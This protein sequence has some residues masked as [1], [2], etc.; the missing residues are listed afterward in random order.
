[1]EPNYF[2]A[3]KDT[4]AFI[5]KRP[6]VFGFAC[7]RVALF[8]LIY[9]IATYVLPVLN[10]ENLVRNN[11]LFFKL[12]CFGDFPC[13]MVVLYFFL[14]AGLEVGVATSRYVQ[15][16]L[17]SASMLNA[18]GFQVINFSSNWSAGL[19][20]SLILTPA[21]FY[22]FKHFLAMP[23]VAPLLYFLT[24]IPLLMLL[25]VLIPTFFLAPFLAQ[26]VNDMQVALKRAW[27]VMRN[28][29]G[30]SLLF[31][32]LLYILLEAGVFVLI[33]AINTHMVLTQI[34]AVFCLA[35][36]LTIKDVFKTVV[37]VK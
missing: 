23:N 9:L 8:G 27:F 30:K 17:R 5:S 15:T 33:N 34:L 21:Y 36:W 18:N 31:I 22:I 32:L 6:A 37:A 29:F 2:M 10:I 19:F 11:A 26:D 24:P 3:L 1:M 20:W 4:L 35:I 16:Y 14:A 12:N 28:N 7:L 13:G 25:L